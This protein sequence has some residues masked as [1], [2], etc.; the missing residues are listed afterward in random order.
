MHSTG[1]PSGTSSGES[2]SLPID[3]DAVASLLARYG[4]L[5]DQESDT[6]WSELFTLDARLEVIGGPIV[7]GRPALKDFAGKSPRGTHVT[8]VPHVE[9]VD[10][11]HRRYSATSSWIFLNRGTGASV[12]GL[13]YDDFIPHSDGSL[14][15]ASRR[16]AMLSR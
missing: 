14:L 4:I 7:E 9:V 10:S 8:G 15:F 5:L 16:I 12:G 3:L 11:Q 6:Q 1:S 13:Y 2:A